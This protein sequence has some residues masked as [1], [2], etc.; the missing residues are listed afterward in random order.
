MTLVH[1]FNCG[2]LTFAPFYVLYKT[3]FLSEDNSKFIYYKSAFAFACTQ[4]VKL[5]L[6]ATFL[7][8]SLSQH[9]VV[10]AVFSALD[11]GGMHLVLKST[12][13]SPDQKVLAIGLGWSC[14]AAVLGNFLPLYQGTI[15]VVEHS[16]S[17]VFLGVAANI[18]LAAAVAF[19]ALVWCC[20]ESK[21]GPGDKNACYA[22][23]VGHLLLQS[24][25][26]STDL[27]DIVGGGGEGGGETL[28]DLAPTITRTALH[29]GLTVAHGLA[30]YRVYTSH[31]T[32]PKVA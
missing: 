24:Y 25:F 12:R 9:F 18:G 15:G 3:T 10:R 7:P 16:V 23:I 5:V 31:R 22:L 19:A 2:L 13:S 1:F 29:A 14:G 32:A 30:A 11:V 6:I 28:A 8:D 17:F 26:A 4:L 21:A 27:D 20:F